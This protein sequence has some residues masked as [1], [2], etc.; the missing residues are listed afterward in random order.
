MDRDSVVCGR[1]G[2]FFAR[3]ADEGFSLAVVTWQWNPLR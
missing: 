3:L 1:A 2:L